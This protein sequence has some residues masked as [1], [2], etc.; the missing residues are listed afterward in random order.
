ML[1]HVVPIDFVTFLPLP[2][3]TFVVT[4]PAL[5]YFAH[6]LLLLP[7]TAICVVATLPLE[8]ACHH[9]PAAG[10]S[11]EEVLCVWCLHLVDSPHTYH[12]TAPCLPF[13][14]L[15]LDAHVP[16]LLEL[17]SVV[18]I[19]NYYWRFWSPCVEFLQHLPFQLVLYI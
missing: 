8:N 2:S 17:F 4:F 14:L 11:G 18:V 10:K 1:D 13:C 16:I 5:L 7:F 9:P 19:P 3:H 12:L 6:H 15:L